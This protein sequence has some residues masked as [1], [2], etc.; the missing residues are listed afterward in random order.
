MEM[1]VQF[2]WVPYRKAQPR[3][4]SEG[5]L[6]Q[7]GLKG[8]RLIRHAWQSTQ[9]GLTEFYEV[10]PMKQLKATAVGN[11]LSPQIPPS[12]GS[13]FLFGWSLVKSVESLCPWLTS[14][15]FQF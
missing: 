11:G 15:D 3:A 4:T 12:S 9:D 1:E 6:E 2:C 10:G 13:L 8:V 5:I 14:E 7:C